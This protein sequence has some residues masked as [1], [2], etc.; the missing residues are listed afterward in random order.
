M[1]QEVLRDENDLQIIMGEST[2]IV[3]SIV[4]RVL[5]QGS[6]AEIF[7]M[8]T[9]CDSPLDRYSFN[10][11]DDL[12]FLILAPGLQSISYELEALFLARSIRHKTATFRHVGNQYEYLDKD[13]GVGD[14]VLFT[15]SAR[16][17]TLKTIFAVAQITELIDAQLGELLMN[18]SRGHEVHGDGSVED[19]LA[20]YTH[21]YPDRVLDSRSLFRVY[22]FTVTRRFM[23]PEALWNLMVQ[24]AR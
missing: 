23:S 19:L 22:R 4:Q 6:Y 5:T 8:M 20:F 18:Y 9:S 21:C 12:G 10:Y 24:F 14:S 15:W 11:Y 13:V 2:A 1:Q 3:P 16:S 7:T 17:G